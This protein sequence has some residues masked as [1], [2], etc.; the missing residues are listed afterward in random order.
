MICTW[1]SSLENPC[2][3][4]SKAVEVPQATRRT[5]SPSTIILAGV[6]IDEGGLVADAITDTCHGLPE[7]RQITKIIKTFKIEK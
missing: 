2:A 5:A 1:I 4:S 7:T 6:A 3:L